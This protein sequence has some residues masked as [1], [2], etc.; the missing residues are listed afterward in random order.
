MP[1]PNC[2][3]LGSLNDGSATVGGPGLNGGGGAL[4]VGTGIGQL[5]EVGSPIVYN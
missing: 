4:P 3:F 2:F 5:Y 1:E